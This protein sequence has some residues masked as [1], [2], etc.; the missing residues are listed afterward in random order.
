MSWPHEDAD[1]ARKHPEDYRNA[2][3]IPCGSD[4]YAAIFHS[5]CEELAPADER[6][7]KHLAKNGEH[8]AGAGARD[9]GG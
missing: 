2:D 6:D 7:A 5:F 8:D 3:G 9:R 4:P 1:R